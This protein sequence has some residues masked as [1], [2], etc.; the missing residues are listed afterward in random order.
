[1]L[2]W[3]L[4]VRADT[5]CE[6]RVPEANIM[7]GVPVGDLIVRLR[8]LEWTMEWCPESIMPSLFA[9]QARKHARQSKFE[10]PVE[11]SSYSATEDPAFESIHF[12]MA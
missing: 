4:E 5:S 9:S 7:T 2:C 3:V 1:M 6:F 10:T 11:N 8:H 12:E